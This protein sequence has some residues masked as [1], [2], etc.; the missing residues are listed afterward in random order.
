MDCKSN[1]QFFSPS[2]IEGTT[3][4]T[5]GNSIS[6]E[7]IKP[8]IKTLFNDG[9]VYQVKLESVGHPTSF[10]NNATLGEIMTVNLNNFEQVKHKLEIFFN[11][12]QETGYIPE[13]VDFPV[14]K[15]IKPEN[16]TDRPEGVFM[17][18]FG[19]VSENGFSA[20][21]FLP[22]YLDDDSVK[23]TFADKD[24]NILKTIN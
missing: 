13:G 24:G 22:L 3:H 18:F 2:D 17:T 8:D 1:E 23:L 4:H 9:N 7:N 19:V 15:I 16:F 14:E 6:C 11:Q 5:S 10:V 21:G 20:Q 12:L